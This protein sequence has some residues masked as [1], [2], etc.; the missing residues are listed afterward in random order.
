MLGALKALDELDAG[1]DRAAERTRTGDLRQARELRLAEVAAELDHD[2]EPAGI[3][4]LSYQPRRSPRQAPTPSSARAYM[5]S[6]VEMQVASAAGKSS[7]GRPAAVAAEP[8]RFVGDQAVLAVDHH[9][10]AERAWYRAGCCGETHM[11]GVRLV[12]AAGRAIG[13]RADS[14]ADNYAAE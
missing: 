12:A 10:L 6:V 9:L 8:L 14:D 7:C 5:T 1:L 2:L 13:A 11:S 4:R 3:E